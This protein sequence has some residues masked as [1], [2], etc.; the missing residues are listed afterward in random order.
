MP[1]QAG[2][3]FHQCRLEKSMEMLQY[4]AMLAMKPVHGHFEVC[5]VGLWQPCKGCLCIGF[6]GLRPARVAVG[7]RCLRCLCCLQRW[8]GD[9]VLKTLQCQILCYM[10]R[11]TMIWNLPSTS[12][13]CLT[14]LWQR[15]RG[16][17]QIL[18]FFWGQ[19]PRVSSPRF[20]FC[21]EKK[22]RRAP[23]TCMP[24]A[25]ERLPKCSECKV[26]SR[27]VAWYLK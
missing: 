5:S 20:F 27:L 6:V 9:K 16:P 26:D 2:A 21:M 8:V 10:A 3:V 22:G 24:K 1:A 15:E 17:E 25:S 13:L 7:A 23:R 4:L 14:M 12:R 18:M 19:D 11:T